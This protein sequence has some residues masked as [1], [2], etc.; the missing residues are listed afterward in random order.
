MEQ[1]EQKLRERSRKAAPELVSEQD[2]NTIQCLSCGHKCTIQEGETGICRMHWNEAG[3]LRVPFGYVS[4]LHVDP[5]EKKPFFHALPGQRALSFGMLGCN[6]QCPYCQ[7]WNIS[8]NLKDSEAR[9]QPR[10]ISPAEIIKQ[11][12]GSNV[13]SVVATYNEPLIT[14]EWSRTIFELAREEDYLTGYVSN[15]YASREVIEYLRDWTDLFNVDFKGWSPGKYREL[16]GD[17]EVVK[18]MLELIHKLGFHLEVITLLVPERTDEPEELRRMAGFLASISPD[19][20]WHLTAFRGAYKW[21]NHPS[22]SPQDLKMAYEIAREEGMNY[23]YCGNLPGRVG[24]AESTYCPEC[25]ELLIKRTGYSIG[26]VNLDENKCP[27]CGQGI[28]GVFSGA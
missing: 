3:E 6:L 26:S 22:T 9:V 13:S 27:A 20:P 25:G 8:Q 23:V 4:S 12:R 2:G 10:D 11:A 14:S 19:I 18:E 1:Y 17:V 16:G 15:G 5:M 28:Y 7:N 21:Q 24:E